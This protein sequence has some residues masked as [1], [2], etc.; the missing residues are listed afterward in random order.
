MELNKTKVKIS[1]YSLALL[2]MGLIASAS[3]TAYIKDAFPEVSTTW[4]QMLTTIPTVS[5][6][7]TTLTTGF[8]V[9]KW[10]K[11]RLILIGV[12]CWIIGGLTPFFV[13][14]FPVMIAMRLLFGVGLGL[15]LPLSI[16][17]IAEVFDGQERA[18]VFGK[19]SAFSMLGGIGYTYGGGWLS[20]LGWQYCYLAYIVGIPVFIIVLLNLPDTGVTP[21]PEGEKETFWS[22]FKLPWEV[23]LVGFFGLLFT[24][25]WFGFSTNI[26]MFVSNA[27]LG[28]SV[29]SGLVSALKNLSGFLTGLIFGMVFKRIR[30]FTLPLAPLWAAIGFF[31]LSKS[32]TMTMVCISS[33]ILGAGDSLYQPTRS[34]VVSNIVPKNLVTNAVS[35]STAVSNLGT[36]FSPIVVNSISGIA[37]ADSAAVPERIK[38]QV[39]VGAYII[40]GI[41]FA[42]YVILRFERKKVRN[43]ETQS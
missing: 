14:V 19:Q 36:F 22:K 35:I 10:S 3:G 6:M 26:S 20:Q 25:F 32:E 24:A 31:M 34:M 16:S 4:I 12:L 41:I 2:G 42:V 40:L 9:R 27:G 30:Y 21:A 5:S 38:F 17:T 18:S 7:A 28:G 23:Y 43:Q 15:T 1:V 29:E 37:G 13:H 8:L 11:K 33:F 39:V